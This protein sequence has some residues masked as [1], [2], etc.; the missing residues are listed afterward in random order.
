LICKCGVMVIWVSYLEQGKNAA[1]CLCRGKWLLLLLPEHCCQWVEVEAAVADLTL[2]TMPPSILLLFLSHSYKTQKENTLPQNKP[3]SF[4]PSF[5][6]L[7]FAP[8]LSSSYLRTCTKLRIWDLREELLWSSENYHTV[9]LL[10]YICCYNISQ[11][12]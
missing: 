1:V 10:W 5:L 12:W 11:P 8:L 6:Q 2:T 7:S 9:A 3:P 4:L